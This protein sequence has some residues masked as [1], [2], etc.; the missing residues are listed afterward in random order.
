MANVVISLG[1]NLNNPEKQLYEA[2]QKII[3]SYYFLH[4]K[5][6]KF[7]R[8]TAI[9]DDPQNDYINAVVIVETHLNPFACLKLLQEFEK[10]QLR[11]RHKNKKWQPR[12][13]DLDI[14]HYNNIT[15]KSSRLTLPHPETWNRKFVLQ[16][17]YEISSYNYQIKKNL[18]NISVIGQQIKV[19]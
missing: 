11:Q 8:T 7:Y 9:T 10:S 16:P 19:V 17:W 13:L 5:F 12:T 4:T 18:S 6:S 15:I 1:S 14:I 2:K 3:A